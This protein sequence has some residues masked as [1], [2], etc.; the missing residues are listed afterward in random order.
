MAI[1]S[2]VTKLDVAKNKVYQVMRTIEEAQSC[3]NNTIAD[4]LA[5]RLHGL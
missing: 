5:E 3:K 4:M 2:S 1:T